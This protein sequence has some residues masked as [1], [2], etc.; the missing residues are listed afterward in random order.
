MA[1][2]AADEAPAALPS[3]PAAQHQQQPSQTEVEA[4][5]RELADIIAADANR[6]GTTSTTTNANAST[7]A[8]SADAVARR[9]RS[10]LP[11]I[12]DVCVTDA[13]GGKAMMEMK[14][15]ERENEKKAKRVFRAID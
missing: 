6:G 8:T 9:L 3:A 2:A 15:R 14:E 1:T 5:A 4:Y 12:L 7:S 11:G 13:P 10:A